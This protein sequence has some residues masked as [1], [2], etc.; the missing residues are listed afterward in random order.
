VA[1]RVDRYRTIAAGPQAIWD[2]LADFGA[3][4]G[5][6]G[7]VDH[8][9]VL[10]HGEGG[11]VGTARR[12]QVGRNTL[13]ERITVFTAPIELAYNISGLP[14]WLGQLANRWTLTPTSTAGTLVTLTSSV[15][16]GTHLPQRIAERVVC[17]VLA[18]P[19]DAMLAGLAD[20]VEN[21]HG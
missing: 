10:E 7:N 16:I 13:V 12:V 1:T 9:S 21:H 17:R 18:N 20:R 6:A 4:S 2:V 11:P 8:S 15:D 3:L 19:S 5:W 14:S